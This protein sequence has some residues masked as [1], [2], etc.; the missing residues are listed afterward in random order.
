MGHRATKRERGNK[1]RDVTQKKRG[2]RSGEEG[3][4]GKERRGE[5]SGEREKR[6]GGGEKKVTERENVGAVRT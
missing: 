4:V 5:L 2:E 6:E 3:S 1:S